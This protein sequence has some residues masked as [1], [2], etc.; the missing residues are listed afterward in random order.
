MAERAFEADPRVAW[1]ADSPPLPDAALF[2]V[3]RHRPSGAGLD[4]PPLFDR[5]PRLASAV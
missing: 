4:L 3:S 1:F 5:R 2:A